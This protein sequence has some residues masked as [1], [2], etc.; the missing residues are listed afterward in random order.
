MRWKYAGKYVEFQRFF[1]EHMGDQIEIKIPVFKEGHD[2]ELG[3]EKY[4]ER[5]N[6]YAKA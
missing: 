6:W 1:V 3:T 4:K 2:P 5:L